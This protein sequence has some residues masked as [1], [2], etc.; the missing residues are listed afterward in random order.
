METAAQGRTEKSFSYIIRVPGSDGF[1]TMNVD[2][3][4]DTSWIFRDGESGDA[5]RGRL[6]EGAAGSLDVATGALAERPGSPERNPLGRHVLSEAGLRR[7]VRELELSEQRLVAEVDRLHARVSRERS[8]ALRAQEQLQALR[9][10]LARRDAPDCAQDEFLPLPREE[11]PA[12]CRSHSPLAYPW[13]SSAEEARASAGQASEGPCTQSCAGAGRGLSVWA[14]GPETM[15]ELPGALAGPEREQLTLPASSLDEQILLLA[16]GCPP[17]Q[18]LDRTVHPGALACTSG[19]S[20]AAGP[21]LESF[22]LLQMCTLPPWGPAGDPALLPL[23]LLREA[24]PEEPQEVPGAGPL[25]F[26]K[27]AGRPSWDCH[28]A[29]SCAASPHQKFPGRGPGGL[30]EPL[31]EAGGAPGW[32]GEEQEAQGTWGRKEESCGDKCRPSPRSPEDLTL[33]N[34]VSA[35]EGQQAEA[36]HGLRAPLLQG[37]A[38]AARAGPVALSGRGSGGGCPWELQGA[39]SPEQEEEAHPATC[40]RGHGV[41]EPSPAG[42][43]SPAERGTAVRR[44]ARGLGARQHPGLPSPEL[45]QGAGPVGLAQDG[46]KVLHLE[47]ARPGPRGALEEPD[48]E[49]HEDTE[50]WISAEGEDSP[51]APGPSASA[52][53]D[54]PANRLRAPRDGGDRRGLR[55]EAFE[56]EL[57][58]CFQQLALLELGSGARAWETSTQAGEDCSLA[59][60]WHSREDAHFQEVW[61]NHG[62]AIPSA[63]QAEPNATDEGVRSGKAEALGPG[64]D[65]PGMEPGLGAASP[66]PVARPTELDRGL[67]SPPPGGLGRLERRFAQLISAL[68]EERRQAFLDH[69]TLREDEE[70]WHG[71]VRAL[72]RE[73]ERSARSIRSLEQEC[74]R[75][76]GDVV[77]LKT[78][79]DQYLQLL[80]ELEDCNGKSYSRISELEEENEQ[81][82]RHLGQVQTAMSEQLQRARGAVE[83]ITLENGQLKALISELRVSYKELIK[84]VVLG[85]EGMIRGGGNGHLLCGIRL[86][87]REVVLDASA[88][89]GHLG[90]GEKHLQGEAKAAAGE[91]DALD[92]AVQVPQL[93]GQEI[94]SAQGPPWQG[95]SAVAGG[96]VGASSCMENSRHGA[97]STAPS[98]VGSDAD[99]P[100]ALGEDVDGG[101]KGGQLEKEE[102]RKWCSVEHGRALGP[103][104]RDPQLLDAEAGA[105]EEGLRLCVRQLRHQVLTLRCQLQDQVAWG[106]GLQAQEEEASHRRAALQDQLEDL[107]KRHHEAKL[108]VAPLQAKVASLVRKCRERN[109]LITLLLRELRRHGAVDPPLSQTARAMVDDVA[110]AEYAACFLPLAAQE[111]RH[112]LDVGPEE[113]AVVQAPNYLP[114]PEMDSVLRRSPDSEPGDEWW[115]QT[116]HLDPRKERRQHRGETQ[117][118]RYLY[119]S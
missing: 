11:V 13:A 117:V 100:S 82:R 21:A 102:K 8:A 76:A 93:P 94:A 112:Q 63:E 84:D 47:G 99:A 4:L 90:R 45:L 55:I 58:A 115:A 106:Q 29:T 37:E 101:V 116:T 119:S 61:A 78:E 40:P 69:A 86:L 52:E 56:K 38:S 32:R 114:D 12:P 1:E 17:G 27:A 9:G 64:G 23:Q 70:R 3:K 105:S 110:L 71:E 14:P 80:S 39:P 91:V 65:L 67:P 15:G 30:E 60:P 98:L 49:G 57:E 7:R 77:R 92:K 25:L 73:R 96:Q 19:P 79:V 5:A 10:E 62:S 59:G 89:A 48:V 66:G 24:S 113:A 34:G 41:Q 51:P 2:V 85:I 104:G 26:P 33:E 18:G 87:E 97:G 111:A 74:G 28:Q 118:R 54:A 81:L 42:L 22:V 68:K 20:P 109:K 31:T 72:E 43:V 108:A 16:C 46:E 6:L 107:Q 50:T 36:G 75:L 95:E 44:R 103:P 88:G 35:P 83:R 53:G